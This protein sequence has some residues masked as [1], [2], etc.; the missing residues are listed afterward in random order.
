MRNEVSF[1]A[2]AFGSLTASI[3]LLFGKGWKRVLCVA[4][5]MCLLLFYA[6]TALVG[7]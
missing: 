4:V 3:L 6:A 2:G 1:A 7:D 5:G